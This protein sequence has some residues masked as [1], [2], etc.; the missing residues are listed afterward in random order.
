[1]INFYQC[2][3]LE[4]TKS[5]YI[6]LGLT[7]SRIEPQCLIFDS[8][9]GEIGFLESPSFLPLPYSCLSFVKESKEEVDAIYKQFIDD[10]ITIP[11]VHEKYPVYSFF[12]KDPNGLTIEFQV[13]ID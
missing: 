3:D 5:F 6:K 1:M 2:R 10:A 4:E 11:S 9:Y 8:G 13:F 12:M 7:L